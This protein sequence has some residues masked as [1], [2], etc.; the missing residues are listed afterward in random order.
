MAQELGKLH[1]G[2]RFGN[3]CFMMLP[4]AMG[5]GKMFWKASGGAPEKINHFK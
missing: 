5:I 3:L 4:E 1:W 2:C